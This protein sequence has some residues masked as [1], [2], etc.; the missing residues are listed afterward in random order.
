MGHS[1]ANLPVLASLGMFGKYLLANS[2]KIYA[3]LADEASKLTDDSQDWLKILRKDV[4][5][6]ASG[7]ITFMRENFHL[8]GSSFGPVNN[9]WGYI[10]EMTVNGIRKG[11]A[12]FA[13]LIADEITSGNITNSDSIKTKTNIQV[14]CLKERPSISR[15]AT[16]TERG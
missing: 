4:N 3:A 2:Q 1:H 16:A 10:K 11:I 12:W 5:D 14:A 13:N 7:A 15:Q 6:V 9:P 8:S